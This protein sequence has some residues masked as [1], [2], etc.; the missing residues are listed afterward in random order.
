MIGD[1]D[2]TTS[3]G[4]GIEQ[5]EQGYVTNTLAPWLRRIEDQFTAS[6]PPAVYAR[7]NLEGRLRGDTLQR[8]QAYTLAR[9]GS[10]MSPDE[11]RAR[12]DM[13]PL[14][15]GIGEDYFAPLNFAPLGSGPPAEPAPGGTQP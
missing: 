6:I 9:N 14:P 10:W 8:Y 3:W 12:E 15:G 5:Q 13:P 4:T 2:K 7:F 11:I 1:V